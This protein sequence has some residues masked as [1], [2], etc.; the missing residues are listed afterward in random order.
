MKKNRTKTEQEEEAIIAE[1]LTGQTS[2]RELEKKHGID[3]R[4]IHSWVT[5]FQGKPLRKQKPKIGQPSLKTEDSPT[6]V[7][8]LQEE[9]RKA[10]L[11]NELL[12]AMIDIAEDQLK[13]DI[14]KKSG[15]K[16]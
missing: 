11:Y 6:D 16:R 2:Y 10:K 7:K 15:T 14:R 3:F 5:K 9:L 4:V 12:N 1:Y 13:I 8:Q